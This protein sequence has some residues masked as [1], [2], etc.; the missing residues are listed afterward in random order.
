MKI[1]N[2]GSLNVDYVYRVDDFLRP[3]ETKACRSRAVFAG[4]KG[5][6][7]SVALAR[8]GAQVYHAGCI[9]SDGAILRTALQE[10]GVHTDWLEQAD[11][12]GGH[13][14]IQVSDAGQNC[15]L[16]YGGT[17]RM[18]TQAYIDTVLGRCAPGDIVLLQNETNLV[19][20][21]IAAAAARGLRVALNASPVDEA[22]LRA[23]LDGVRWLVI[24]EIEGGMLAHTG[25]NEN[26]I[27]P[28]LAQRW[29]ACAVVLTLGSRG[30]RYHDAAQDLQLDACRVDRVVDTT[31][32]GD[33]FLGYFLACTAEGMP[34]REAL[35]RS[36]M[37][38]A[39][40]I[41]VQGAAGSIPPRAAVEQALAEGRFG[42][43]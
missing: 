26:E 22:L 1:L 4:G 6:N 31:A 38:S 37:A 12:A 27:L 7:Q 15:I 29:P 39:L 3:G 28:A 24:N 18:L 13:T 10:A 2:I 32:A 17:N 16:L 14:V 42:M 41:Q 19:D 5:L 34:A 11:T 20:Y 25:E 40:A 9:G 36:T 21:A 43:R 23:P 30:V 8:A 33:T 35:R